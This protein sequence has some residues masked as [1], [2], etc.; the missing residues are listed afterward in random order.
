MGD[1]MAWTAEE[2]QARERE[3]TRIGFQA[4]DLLPSP[5]HPELAHAAGYLVS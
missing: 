2:V 3:T 5:G 4:G 1:T